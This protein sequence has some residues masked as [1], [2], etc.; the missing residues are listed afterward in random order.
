MQKQDMEALERLLEEKLLSASS[1]Q[2]AE[3]IKELLR[4][5]RFSSASKYYNHV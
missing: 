2:E 3:Y 4:V 5:V 1:P